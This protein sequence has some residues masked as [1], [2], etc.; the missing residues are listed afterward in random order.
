MSASTLP[1]Y[2]DLL[3][4]SSEEINHIQEACVKAGPLRGAEIV[5]R[6]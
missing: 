5:D 2:P 6:R 1:S 4:L 3:T